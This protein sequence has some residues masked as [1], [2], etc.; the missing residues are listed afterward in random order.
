MILVD[1]LNRQGNLCTKCTGSKGREK[2]QLLLILL[3][4]SGEQVIDSKA[5]AA[6]TLLI[7]VSTPDQKGTML[8][9][10]LSIINS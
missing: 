7:A 2:N 3:T 1:T 10:I 5:L 4:S 8:L 6:L 9:V